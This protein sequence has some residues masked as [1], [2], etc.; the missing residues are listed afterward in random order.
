MAANSVA[1]IGMAG[2]DRRGSIQLLRQQHSHQAVGPGHAPERQDQIRALDQG[3]MEAIRPADQKG[4]LAAAL[5][6]PGSDGGRERAAAQGAAVLIARDERGVAR[7]GARQAFGLLGA[8]PL[9]RTGRAR[10]NFEEAD[11]PRAAPALFLEEIPRRAAAV[12]PDRSDRH[13]HAAVRLAPGGARL[14]AQANLAG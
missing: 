13:A 11:R 12:T 2:E 10:R 14:G 3:R 6:L 8:A 9:G 4:Q 7:N 1:M 5:P